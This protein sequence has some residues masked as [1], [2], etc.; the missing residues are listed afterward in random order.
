M[1]DKEG[2]IIMK[3]NT[4]R[5]R[6]VVAQQGRRKWQKEDDICLEKRKHLP[7]VSWRTGSPAG[8]YSEDWDALQ[9]EEYEWQIPD[10]WQ[11]ILQMVFGRSRDK[12]E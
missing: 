1:E 2:M 6:D 11:R 7:L 8:F 9:Q 12:S 5:K 4:K 10:N 3:T